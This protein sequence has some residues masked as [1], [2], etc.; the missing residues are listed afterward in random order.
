MLPLVI[1]LMPYALVRHGISTLTA[2]FRSRCAACDN[3]IEPGTDARASGDGGWL[4][5][6][7]DAPEPADAR[8]PRPTA[9]A[10]GLCFQVPAANG[11]CGCDP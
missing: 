9:P 5:A 1:L 7:C 3:P 4:H 10:C 11:V 2:R 8:A 6:D